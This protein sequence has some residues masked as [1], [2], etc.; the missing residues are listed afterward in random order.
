MEKQKNILYAEDN[1]FTRNMV[2]MWL[3]EELRETNFERYDDGY[4]LEKRLQQGPDGIDLVL[5]DNNMPGP[6]GGE[7]IRKYARAPGFDKIPFILYYGGEPEIGER[8]VS[9]GAFAYFEKGEEAL[10]LIQLIKRALK[11]D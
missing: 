11:I 8:A 9:D 6:K 2:L 7:I 4:S 10:K 5:T 1:L 3:E